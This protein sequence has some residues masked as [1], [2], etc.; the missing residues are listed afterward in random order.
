MLT[1]R[2]QRN[3]WVLLTVAIVLVMILG[4]LAFAGKKQSTHGKSKQKG[5]KTQF[6]LK[7]EN[8]HVGIVVK[9]NNVKV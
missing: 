3:D 6:V 1:R 5:A 4:E 7:V 8:N 9:N 2:C